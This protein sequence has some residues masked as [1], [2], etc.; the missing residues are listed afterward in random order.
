MPIEVFF[1]FLFD[2]EIKVSPKMFICKP[3]KALDILDNGWNTRRA[4][5]IIFVLQVHY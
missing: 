4:G 5:G 3:S 2:E 1:Y